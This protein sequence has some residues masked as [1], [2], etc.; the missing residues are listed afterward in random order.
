MR[1][2]QQDY[3]DIAQR[4]GLPLAVVIRYGDKILQQ[5]MKQ[6]I[7]EIIPE[8]YKYAPKATGQLRN[9]LAHQLRNSTL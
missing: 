2:T 1:I 4:T 8:I 6:T 7:E 5:S 3:I 9:S